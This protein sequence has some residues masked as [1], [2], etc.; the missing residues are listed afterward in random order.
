MFQTPPLSLGPPAQLTQSTYYPGHEGPSFEED[1]AL[2]SKVMD[3]LKIHPENTRLEK[4]SLSLEY[5]VFNILQA[6]VAESKSICHVA[7]SSI[8]SGKTILLV[9][10]D[11]KNELARKIGRAHV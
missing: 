6:S 2:V 4:R 3:E 7:N 11:Y 8:P 9:N 10:G 1:A 5:E